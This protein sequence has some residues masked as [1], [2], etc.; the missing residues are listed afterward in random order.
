MLRSSEILRERLN[1]SWETTKEDQDERLDK[2]EFINV[3]CYDLDLCFDP[4]LQGLLMPEKKEVVWRDQANDHHLPSQ[5]FSKKS[6]HHESRFDGHGWD[7]LKV[8]GLYHRCGTP[9]NWRKHHSQAK[10]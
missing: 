3:E 10:Q 6:I 2:T 8:H 9:P 4:D 5:D 7:L 1:N